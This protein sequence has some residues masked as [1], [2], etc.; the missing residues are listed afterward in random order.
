MLWITAAA[1]LAAVAP[2]GADA[3]VSVRGPEVEYRHP[4]SGLDVPVR[5]RFSWRL[6]NSDPVARN[7]TQ[8]AY[9]IT[10]TD[11]ATNAS[12]WDSGRIASQ[13]V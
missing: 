12:L 6:E 5:P 11:L 8:L 10:V 13:K 9:A 4:G 3:A 1:L 2:C 7:T